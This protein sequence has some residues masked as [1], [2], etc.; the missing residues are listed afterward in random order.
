[1]PPKILF[2]DVGTHMAQ[3][4]AALFETRRRDFWWKFIK[5]R[6]R[7]WKKGTPAMP[8]DTFDAML[9]NAA[10]LQQQRDAFFYVMVEPNPHLFALPIYRRADLALNTALLTNAA[11]TSLMPLFFSKGNRTGQGSSLFAAKPNVD[12][13]DFQQVLALD[14]LHFVQMMKVMFDEQTKGGD[15]RVI[16]R[17]NNEGAEVEVIKAFEGVFGSRLVAVLGSLLDVG[18]V[19]GQA[20]LDALY[21]FMAGKDIPFLPLSPVFATW[22]PAMTLI[23]ERTGGLCHGKAA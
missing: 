5:S 7:A 23:R 18:K 14:A 17:L 19:K 3:E 13:S 22:A 21:A 15:Y 10:W 1:M 8:R 11:T 16:L 2:V 6:E 4:Y 9:G 20:E 12:T